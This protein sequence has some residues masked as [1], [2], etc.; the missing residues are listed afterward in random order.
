MTVS[1]LPYSPFS[2]KPRLLERT[3]VIC[4]PEVMWLS[5]ESVSCK[6]RSVW[7]TVPHYLNSRITRSSDGEEALNKA[8]ACRGYNVDGSSPCF[9]F[10]EKDR[11]VRV[12]DVTS[13]ENI[14]TS[15]YFQRLCSVIV[16]VGEFT[17]ISE[18]NTQHFNTDCNLYK[19]YIIFTIQYKLYY[20]N[21][22]E[23]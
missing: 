15:Y 21:T 1:R 7:S 13:Q 18:E 8:A 12:V 11:L 16:L 20:V 5:D 10:V 14:L 19:M 4:P 23:R 2:F 9:L 6:R 22:I 3:A 17:N